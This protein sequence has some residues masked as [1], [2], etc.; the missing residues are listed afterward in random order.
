MLAIEPITDL[1][2]WNAIAQRFPNCDLRQSHEWG[3]IRRRHGWR[4]V[5]LAAFD[6]G[7]CVAAI[8][9]LARRVPG[10]GTIA[11]APRGPLAD[12]DDER[13]W[14]ALPALTDAV[15][16]AT[17]AVFLRV[18]PG[19]SDDRRETAGRLAAHGFVALP[20]FW[21]LWNSPRNV[22][23]LSLDGSERELLSRMASKRR[24]HISTAA[25]R[26]VTAERA[27]GPDALDAFHALLVEHGGRGGYPVRDRGYFDALH[28]AFA[29]RGALG[30]V[31]GRVNGRLAA[32]LLGVRFGAAAYALYA[33]S[34]PAAR[35]RPVGDVLHWEWLRWAKTSGCREI[36]FGSSGTQVPPRPT[37]GALGIYRFK[38]EIGCRLQLNLPFHDRVFDP[39]RYR[40]ARALERHALGRA[41]LWVG[42]LPA[43]LREVVAR[44]VA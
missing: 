36:D 22:M 43:R 21:S 34:S 26:G 10:L 35:G 42:R 37:D 32:A 39:L 8:S 31:V 9:A 12:D 24:Q 5:R 20:D 23:R 41:R 11:Y 16:Q 15:G 38:V 17:G 1:E 6:S 28:A 13:A 14:K 7:H 44:R 19:L 18:S 3:E 33:P 30:L 27:G 25:R 4:P 2:A 29:P 40:V